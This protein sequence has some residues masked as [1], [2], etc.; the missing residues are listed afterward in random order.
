MGKKGVSAEGTFVKA[1]A[2]QWFEDTHAFVKVQSE[3]TSS[4]MCSSSAVF[5]QGVD[6]NPT[7]MLVCERLATRIEM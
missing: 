2:L 6:T 5:L 1:L 4:L 3:T 7:Q